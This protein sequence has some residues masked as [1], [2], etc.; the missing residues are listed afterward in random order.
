MD[1]DSLEYLLQS[2]FEQHYGSDFQPVAVPV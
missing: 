1:Q 2:F